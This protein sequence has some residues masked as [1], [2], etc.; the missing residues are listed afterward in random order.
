MLLSNDVIWKVFM[1]A[2]PIYEI[3]HCGESVFRLAT[4]S[5]ANSL[6]SRCGATLNIQTQGSKS[7]ID[8]LVM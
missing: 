5:T 7:R 6:C 3:A 2:T 1:L 4:S 8:F